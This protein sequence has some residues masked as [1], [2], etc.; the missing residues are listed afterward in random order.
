MTKQPSRDHRIGDA[1][2]EFRIPEHGPSFWAAL[3]ARLAGEHAPRR[4]LSPLPPFSPR[5]RL[6]AA[7]AVAAVGLALLAFGLPRTGAP[8][9]AL[10]Q[11]VKSRVQE[12]IAEL[13][14]VRATVTQR[15]T[16]GPDGRLAIGRERFVLTSAGDFRLELLEGAFQ[17]T[18]Y[19]AETGT[20]RS[21]TESASL[22]L[23][24]F[25]VVR[26]GVAPGSPDSGP[27]ELLADRALAAAVQALL[28]ASDP[29][30]QETSYRGRPSWRL[31]TPVPPNAI[32]TDVDRLEITVDQETGLPVEVVATLDGEFVS[33]L[34]VSD[35]VVDPEL[36][37]RAFVLRFPPGADVETTDEGF[38]RVDLEDAAARV[39]YIPPVPRSL[40]DGYRLAQVAVA[41]RV[42]P[43]GPAGENPPSRRVVSLSYR[44]GFDQLVVTSRLTGSVRDQ[45]A[46]PFAAPGDP[47]QPE[48]VVL[49]DGALAGADAHL[50]VSPRAIPHLWTVTEQLVVTVAGN[51]GRDELLDV[52]N[53]MQQD[54]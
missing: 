22:G 7:T 5:W 18:V 31:V 9:E 43:T 11:E 20:E 24:R 51:V 35:L 44:R 37:E 41:S 26:R 3:E 4:S 53:S 54:G 47:A 16:E 52:A 12:A 21:I 27:F 6:A 28:A 30:V 50:V 25:Y 14:A 23:G 49:A 17:E 48:E 13:E 38:R 19:D 40:P 42:E 8:E 29:E 10:A 39:G 45:W 2:R 15:S 34:R 32:Y 1:L 46:D 36:P 33:E